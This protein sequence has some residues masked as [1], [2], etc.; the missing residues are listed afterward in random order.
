MTIRIIDP[1]PDKSV[2]KEVVCRNCGVKLEYTPSDVQQTYKLDYTGGRDDIDYI[3]CPKCTK[4]ITL[5]V[6]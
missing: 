5:R 2:V 4:N 3:V 6:W 1:N